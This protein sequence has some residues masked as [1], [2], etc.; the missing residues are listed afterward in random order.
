MAFNELSRMSNITQTGTTATSAALSGNI[1][2]MSNYESVMFIGTAAA[3]N[4]SAWV[5]MQMGT[6]T[7]AMSDATGEAF[8]GA[9][10]KTNM[11][12]DVQRPT[13]RY[14]RGV[15]KG[16]STTVLY[17]TMQTIQYNAKVQPTTHS[18]TSTTGTRLYS[19]GSGT[20]TG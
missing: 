15:F 9:G 14:V 19:P 12:L 4:A 8:E 3:S 13:K 10:S 6:A 18:D 20:A 16:A 2:D 5:K 7:D 11:Y 1:V 17:R